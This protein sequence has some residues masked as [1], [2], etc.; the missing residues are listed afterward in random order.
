MTDREDAKWLNKHLVIS[1][2]EYAIREILASRYIWNYS[3]VKY[4]R[5]YSI[6]LRYELLTETLN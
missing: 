1:N 5:N 4:E 3:M 6:I 2:E